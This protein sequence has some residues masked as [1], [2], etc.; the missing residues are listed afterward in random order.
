MIKII[1]KI[2]KDKDDE[3]TEKK[4]TE[5]KDNKDNDNNK[6]ILKFL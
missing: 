1:K 6:M 4:I 5:D 3:I 2:T